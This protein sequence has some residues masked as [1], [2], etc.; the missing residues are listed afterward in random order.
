MHGVL[1]QPRVEGA[2]PVAARDGPRAQGPAHAARGHVVGGYRRRI[3]GPQVRRPPRHRGL[4]ARAAATRRRRTDVPDLPA[5]RAPR[6]AHRV[7]A[8]LPAAAGAG[9]LLM[10][11][12]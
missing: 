4:V 12:V 7:P 8:R 1:Q 11:C 9:F 10:R 6:D 3:P 5:A 2:V